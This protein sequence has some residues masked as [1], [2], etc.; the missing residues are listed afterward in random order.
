MICSIDVT[1]HAKKTYRNHFLKHFLLSWNFRPPPLSIRVLRNF[2]N[3][4]L[5][6][7]GIRF[8]Y[9]PDTTCA[10]PEAQKQRSGNQKNRRIQGPNRQWSLETLLS[11]YCWCWQLTLSIC[12]Y[13]TPTWLYITTKRENDKHVGLIKHRP[14]HMAGESRELECIRETSIYFYNTPTWLYNHKKRKK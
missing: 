5:A 3:I 11:V 14:T 8:T 9:W 7:F 12:L 1:M 4:L 13:N 10:T 2:E 6:G